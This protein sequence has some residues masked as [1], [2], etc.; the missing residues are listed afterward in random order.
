MNSTAKREKFKE[1]DGFEIQTS[2]LEENLTAY[3]LNAI[4]IME[5][6]FGVLAENGFSDHKKEQTISLMK[7]S[8]R[9]TDELTNNNMNI[10]RI[11]TEEQ[12]K[13]D[14]NQ[15]DAVASEKKAIDLSMIFEY[16]GEDH[17]LNR[18]SIIQILQ[19]RFLS[20]DDPIFSTTSFNEQISPEVIIEKISLLVVCFYGMSTE[21]RFAEHREANSQEKQSLIH[22]ETS[23]ITPRFQNFNLSSKN[24]NMDAQ[25]FKESQTK[26]LKMKQMQINQKITDS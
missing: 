5:Y 18:S 10:V 21:K 23:E 17:W 22:K 11:Q 12:E 15:F 2:D 7:A 13:M 1:D 9:D 26:K 3:V 6:V 24:I 16:F 20:M 19:H 4:R 25:M 8:L 14:Q